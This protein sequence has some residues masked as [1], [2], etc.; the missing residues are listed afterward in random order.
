MT[1]DRTPG[2]LTE[3]TGSVTDWY[4]GVARD[5]P[6]R[7]PD[8][9]PWGVLV[10]EVMAQQTPVGR[11]AP[12]WEHWMTRWPTP[13]ALSRATTAD[14]LRAWGA[15]GY[16]RRAL[17]LQE[18]GAAIVERHG[19]EVPAGLDALR[20]LP[21]IGEYTAS[22]VAVFA[23]GERHPVVDVNVRR[24]LARAIGGQAEPAPSLSA[25]ERALAQQVLPV[26]PLQA[27]QWSV[28]SMELGALICTAR[29]PRC[30]ECPIVHGCAWQRAGR[31]THDGPVRRVQAFEGTDRQARG[32]LLRA[33]READR[34]LRR[35][36]LLAHCPDANQA[37]RALASLIEDGLVEQTGLNCHLPGDEA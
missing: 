26:E 15:L 9:T 3:L 13:E 32:R 34:P 4:A 29:A 21:G 28:A 24:V 27:A 25:A 11:V 10:S 37:E 31:P 18:A 12:L 2:E 17:R 35:A 1:T 8:T 36:D 23:F 19:G 33:L 6:W 5:L 7:R 20:A 16:P 22:A 30:Q 14:V